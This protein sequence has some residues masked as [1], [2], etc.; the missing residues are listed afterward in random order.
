MESKT[1]Q[2]ELRNEFGKNVNNRLRESGFVPAVIYSH[3]KAENI[4]V[5]EKDLFNL[6]R[7]HIS[8]SVIFDL[9][10]NGSSENAETMAFVKDY[11]MDPVTERIIHLDLF[12]VTRGE[13]IHTKVP[14]EITGTPKGV[15]L[16]GMLEVYAHEIEVECL[17]RDLPEKVTIDVTSL[18][19]DKN[20]HA[21][22]IAL[23][24]SIKLV[25]NPDNV[26]VAVHS[27]RS[28]KEGEGAEEGRETAAE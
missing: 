21:K 27:P 3:G 23:G 20:I 22:D 17:P 24:D 26:I 10:I 19:L 25:S 9:K 16:G 8:E 12:R 13:K 7:G 15:K 14:L 4:K 5:Q 2:A 18:E 11:Q 6:F 28:A 1:L